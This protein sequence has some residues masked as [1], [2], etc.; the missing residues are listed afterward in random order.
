M[1]KN[2]KFAAMIGKTLE[3][4]MLSAD[5]ETVTFTFTDTA[6]VSFTTDADCCSQTWIESFDA[7]LNLKGK[8]LKVEEVDMPDLGATGTPHHPRVDVVQY[9]GVKITTE[10]GDCVI[11]YRN[12]SN[13]YY[14][15]SLQ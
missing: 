11:D 5:R 12:D 6:P 7:P 9:Y 10:R 14:G 1:S 3:S 8:V 2:E 4:C 15:G 13:G